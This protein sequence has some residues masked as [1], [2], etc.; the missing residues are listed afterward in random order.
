LADIATAI[1]TL[2]HDPIFVK[3]GL[4][5]L[6]LNCLL[7]PFVPIPTEIAVSALVLADQSLY[8]ILIVLISGSIIGSFLGYFAGY[9]G[10]KL[11]LKLHRRTH[12]KAQEKE[13]R[14]LS[15]YSWLVI[16]FSPWLPFVGNAI[17]IT[18]GVKKYNL[19]IFSLS[20]IAGQA[21][22]AAATV[23]L[24]N[25]ILTHLLKGVLH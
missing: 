24:I 4:A 15:K 9:S 6:F 12:T 23:F 19:T 11:F 22:K 21:L 13:H 20:I 14:L 25:I 2:L 5:G 16:L 17:V 3:F 8:L 10:N 18:A 1:S 7:S